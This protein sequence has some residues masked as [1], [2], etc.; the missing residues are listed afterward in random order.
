MLSGKVVVI[1]GA[2]SGIGQHLVDRM[3]Q[4]GCRI[5]ATDINADAMDAH[6][7]QAGWSENIMRRKLDVR[8]SDQWQSIMAE[9]IQAWGAIG[10]HDEYRRIRHPGIRPRYP[11]ETH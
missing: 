1:T 11:P 10:H 3:D 8:D 4:M 6:A 2:A 5:L 7:E 9:T